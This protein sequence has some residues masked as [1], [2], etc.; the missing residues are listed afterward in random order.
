MLGIGRTASQGYRNPEWDFKSLAY[1]P[2][3]M[4]KEPSIV[5][6]TRPL[7]Q[8][9][10][11]LARWRDVLI[12][13]LAGALVFAY[14]SQLFSD[15]TSRWGIW[16]LGDGHDLW[17]LLG[18]AVFI[19][20]ALGYLHKAVGTR[21]RHIRHLISYPPLPVTVLLGILIAPALPSFQ[22][23]HLRN[24]A[25]NFAFSA[26][27]AGIYGIMWLVQSIDWSRAVQ[28]FTMRH[29]KVPA[30][31]AKQRDFLKWL[32]SEEPISEKAHDLFEHQ[33]IAERILDRLSSSEC[34][35]ALQGEYGSG[36]SGVCNLAS[37]ISRK[38][39]MPLIFANV[40][41]W[42]F[43]NAARAQKEVLE[44]ILCVVQKEVDCV[45]IRQLP[46][47][48]IDALSGSSGW[49][50]T[51]FCLGSPRLSP[52][53]QLRR[54]SPILQT[55]GKR[56]VVVI[57]D[58]DRSGETFDLSQ[59]QAMLMQFR[60]VDGISFILAISPMQQI[61]FI[62][63]CDHLE[64][65]PELDNAIVFRILHETRE[66][67]LKD[68]P[69]GILL[70]KLDPLVGEDDDYSIYEQCLGYMWPW[71]LALCEL[72]KH[73][74][75]L[76]HALRY[77]C[78]AWPR[79]KGEVH[80]DDLLGI[81]A[82]RSGA[83]EAFT[84]LCSNYKLFKPATKE[85]R[86]L[87][88]EARLKLK[89]ELEEKW[90]RV[91]SRRA[92]DQKSAVAVLKDIYPATAGITGI[93][94]VS[95]HVPQSM[96]SDRRRDVYARRLFTGNCTEDEE[97]DQAILSWIQKSGEDPSALKALAEAITDSK[98]A[99]AAFEDFAG[100]MQFD[101]DLPLLSHVYE[102]IRLRHGARADRDACPGFFAPWRRLQH[103]LPKDFEAWL[104]LELEKCIPGHMRLL[105]N[106]YYYWLGT[107]RHKFQERE[108]PRNAIMEGLKKAW[109]RITP[110]QLA[111]G[112][113]PSFAYT[114]FHLI[115]T[116]DYQSPNDVPLSKTEDWSWI[117]PFLF[118]AAKKQPNIMLPQILVVL[119]KDVDRGFEIPKY[120]LDTQRLQT[121][122]GD[123]A[124]SLLGLIVNGF[125][126]SSG[127]TEQTQYLLKQGITAAGQ[128][129][130]N[131]A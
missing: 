129:L 77:L 94:S 101:R 111:A 114:L 29:H 98:A 68:Y 88:D 2:L 75:I 86:N 96:Q 35:I 36:K 33:K 106:I 82:L 44:A 80:F 87:S 17:G 61:D 131:K 89:E 30:G 74:R 39:D 53:E 41:C 55:I 62:K 47:D 83:P 46:E 10:G 108:A 21:I 58:V 8:T 56:L 112:F 78:D 116:T 124:E 97:S 50:Q 38:Q 128:L 7:K 104:I 126:S 109:G 54:L 15:S 16:L 122:F 120:T 20:I 1:L 5:E 100:N 9:L 40:S 67:L 12:Y 92:F 52:L 125:E 59:I 60:E 121:L 42:G 6:G 19:F 14:C 64:L 63:L 71:Q 26:L 69:P 119:N 81:A 115:Y 103:N 117:G 23:G 49:L 105:S 73:P 57:E 3:R 99:T 107:D 95:N 31:D 4:N 45:A 85:D 43:E 37:V 118:E 76:K 25:V 113:D 70:S 27:V 24:E 48:Y 127:T 123:S 66:S 90:K 93:S 34:A 13:T 22:G 18:A 72:L 32:A 51:L 28:S 102:T 130:D 11:T 79:L 110:D 65:M 84:F 91:C